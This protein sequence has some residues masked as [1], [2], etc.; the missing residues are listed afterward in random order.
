M[1][2]IDVPTASK[3][4]PP[5]TAAGVPGYFTDGD[6]NTPPTIVPAEWLNNVM[7]EFLNVLAVV[8]IVPAKSQAGQ[9]AAAIA[10]MVQ[11][12]AGD[13]VADTGAANAYVVA[14][15]PAVTA[16]G[17]GLSI[18]F[19]SRR[20]NTDASTLDAGAG[21]VPLLRSDGT[22]LRKGDVP[23]NSVVSTVF[24][25]AAKAFLVTGIVLSQLG[26]L[27]QMGLGWGV[28][29]DGAGNLTLKLADSSLV[30][31]ADGLRATN[32][33]ANGNTPLTYFMG[34]M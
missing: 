33:I 20:A 16:Y 28:Q 9:V 10:L 19:R 29:Q 34:Q 31:G 8:G 15:T 7:G 12:K 5:P 17:N 22:P 24:D 2:Q 1:Y 3:D 21:P 26:L 13:Y 30:L 11:A 14:L 18:K 23:P 6:V 32:T 27:A 25:A 4:L